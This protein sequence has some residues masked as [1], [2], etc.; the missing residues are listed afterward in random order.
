MAALP[1]VASR[2]LVI[3]CRM[4]DFYIYAA[5]VLKEKERKK[6]NQ[7]DGFL[8]PCLIKCFDNHSFPQFSGIDL[9]FCWN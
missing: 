9:Y 3:R 6:K 1:A 5:A 8:N 2:F 4:M 7:C